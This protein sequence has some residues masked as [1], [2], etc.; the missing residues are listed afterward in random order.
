MFPRESGTEFLC[1]LARQIFIGSSYMFYSLSNILYNIN[2]YYL[3]PCGIKAN[4]IHTSIRNRKLAS[5]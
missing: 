2:Q 3:I 4:L 5:K 1:G